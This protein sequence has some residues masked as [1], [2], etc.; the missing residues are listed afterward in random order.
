MTRID[1]DAEEIRRV[2]KDIH[3][4]GETIRDTIRHTYAQVESVRVMQSPKLE[5]DIH[6]W[7][8]IKAV[9]DRAASAA[10]Q[11][12]QLLMRFAD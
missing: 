2:S 3:T 4:S 10:I 11:A 12:S 1:V 6:E 7:E 9:L 8:E 5:R